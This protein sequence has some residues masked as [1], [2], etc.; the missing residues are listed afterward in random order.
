MELSQG[1]RDELQT[2]K[3]LLENPGLAAKL[4]GY[5]GKPIEWGI[6]LLPANWAETV[7]EVTTDSLK[8]AANAALFTMKDAPG[9]A[10]WNLAHTLGAS[11]AGALGGFFGIAT[12]PLELP[13]TTTLMLRSILDIARSQGESIS[14]PDVKLACL[15]VFALGS[16]KTQSDDATDTGYF[17]VRTAMSKAV[18]KAVSELAAKGAAAITPES[19][20]ALLK[21]IAQI[22][23]RFSI[24]VSEKA[25]A[26]ALP[27]IG[28]A[29]GAAINAAFM[30]HYQDMA[31]GHFTIR[32]LGRKYGDAF[33]RDVYD[34]L[35]SKPPK[36]IPVDPSAEVQVA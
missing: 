14:E 28:A 13:V 4:S 11:A 7:G 31:K 10:P 29:T 20:S 33:V 2:A 12:L 36:A 35:P 26:Q 16:D 23:S 27:F 25:A 24:V 3:Y 1:E 21:A 6:G 17:A 34:S 15:E 32:R 9:G 8:A 30:D 18:S 5:V 22:A 19:S